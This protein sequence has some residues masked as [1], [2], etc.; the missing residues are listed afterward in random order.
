MDPRKQID[1]GKGLCVIYVNGSKY[2]IKILS[3]V[4]D[5]E[6]KLK[7]EEPSDAALAPS[8]QFLHI[9]FPSFSTIQSLQ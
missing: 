4:I 2:K 7:S 8:A 3:L 9:I 6:M 5:D 1:A